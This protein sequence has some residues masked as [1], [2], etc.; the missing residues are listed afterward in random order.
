MSLLELIARTTSSRTGMQHAWPAP[1]P[2]HFMEAARARPLR[3]VMSDQLTRVSTALA[4]D[5]TNRLSSRFDCVHVPSERLWVEWGETARL[6]ALSDALAVP[7]Q[8]S[9]AGR[10]GALIS[11][12]ASGR[13][14]TIRS[15][16]STFDDKAYSAALITDFDLNHPIR[17]RTSIAGVFTGESAG[18][19]APEEPAFDALLS[20]LRFR[21]DPAWSDHYRSLNLSDEQQSA[22]L[23][24]ALGST[25]FII[26]ML[27]AYFLLLAATGDAPVESTAT[28]SPSFGDIYA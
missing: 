2:Q 15:F 20:H 4:Y 3:L 28:T 6:E 17:C 25:A 13:V 19:S 7:I 12:D 11:S 27:F 22:A 23:S 26:P 16:W 10:A 14:G 9:A 5:K 24:T 21:L 1:D 8:P 18:I